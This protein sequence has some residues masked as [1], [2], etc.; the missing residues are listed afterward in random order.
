MKKDSNEIQLPDYLLV[1]PD[2]KDDPANKQGEIG[3]IT[4]AILD[5]DEF[6][7]GFDDHEVG[8][9]SASAL[10]TFKEPGEIYDL[11]HQKALTLSVDDFKDLKNIALLLDHGTEKHVRTAMELVKKN[12]GIHDAV[13]IGLDQF[14]GI[15]QTR[16][17][18]R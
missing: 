2:L 12:G 15:D 8:F 16:G 18:K 9:Y 5:T 6:Y 4:A 7:V 10:L 11:L 13:T 17:L 3:F 14:L 1:H